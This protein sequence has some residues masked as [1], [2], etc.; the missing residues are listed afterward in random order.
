MSWALQ[1][2]GALLGIWGI[3]WH[4]WDHYAD[5]P[6]WLLGACLFLLALGA[7]LP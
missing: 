7:V 4:M 5:A 6:G 3:I 1:D 2:I